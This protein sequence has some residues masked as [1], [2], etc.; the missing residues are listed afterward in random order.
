[1]T[2]DRRVDAG[3]AAVDLRQVA[4]ALVASFTGELDVSNVKV[5]QSTIISAM[6]GLPWL[7]VLDFTDTRYIDSS[8]VAMVVAFSVE[9]A[10]KRGHLALIAP[11]GCQAQRV[12]HF[13]GVAGSL[14]IHDDEESA[15]AAT[16]N[17]PDRLV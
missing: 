3:L 4:R 16:A 1:M 5:V 10:T 17:T 6:D 14:D 13:S 11:A 12:L 9:I 2:A 7:L 8:S 15:L